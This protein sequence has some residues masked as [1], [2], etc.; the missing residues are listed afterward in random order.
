VW[1]VAY[2]DRLALTVALFADKPGEKKGTTVPAQLPTSPSPTRF[3][4]QTATQLWGRLR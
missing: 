3:A 4:E 1:T 2:D